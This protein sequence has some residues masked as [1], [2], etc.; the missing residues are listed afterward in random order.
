M[1]D[2]CL[3]HSFLLLG[4]SGSG[5]SCMGYKSL[6]LGLGELLV[7]GGHFGSKHVPLLSPPIAIN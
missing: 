2:F 1:C 7:L 3:Y 4:F 5:T 6:S